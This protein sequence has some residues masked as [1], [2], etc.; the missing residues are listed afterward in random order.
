M[1][2]LPTEKTMW[3]SPDKGLFP[4]YCGGEIMNDR[5]LQMLVDYLEVKTVPPTI[6]W[7]KHWFE[8]MS[9][10]RWAVGEMLNLVSDHPFK[11]AYDTIATFAL[12]MEVYAFLS[13]GKS[14]NRIFSVAAE[15]ANEFLDLI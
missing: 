15:V 5:V 9:F 3:K 13:D 12:K 11:S 10:A 4:F 7:P 1:R 2:H 8:E 6:G 14:S